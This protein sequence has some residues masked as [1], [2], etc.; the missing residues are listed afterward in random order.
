MPKTHTSL[1]V[2]SSVWNKWM[3]FCIDKTGNAKSTS[4]I[5]EKA[6]TEYMEAHP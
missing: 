5:A 2:E 3:K 1:T 6:F 4:E